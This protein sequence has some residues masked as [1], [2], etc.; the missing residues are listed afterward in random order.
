MPRM[1]V[2]QILFSSTDC[3]QKER[4]VSANFVWRFAAVTKKTI[5]DEYNF[6][7]TNLYLNTPIPTRTPVKPP[8]KFVERTAAS[9]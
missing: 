3:S 8:A 5:K 6:F 4:A 1:S 9:S 2:S 7:I